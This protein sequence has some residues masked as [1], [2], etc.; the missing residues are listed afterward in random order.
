[1][2]SSNSYREI[3]SCSNTE[4]YQARGLG[5]K[6][7]VDKQSEFVHTLNGTGTSLNRL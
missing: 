4:D 7:A 1:M 2:P 6:Y 5:I 3:S